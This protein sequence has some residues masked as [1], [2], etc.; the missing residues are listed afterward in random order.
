MLM[1]LQKLAR[2]GQALNRDPMQELGGITLYSFALNDPAGWGDLFGLY[3]VYPDDF[4][5]PLP[6]GGVHQSYDDLRRRLEGN[7]IEDDP[8]GESLLDGLSGLL[9]GLAPPSLGV[10]IG[11]HGRHHRFGSLGKLPH[12]QVATWRPGVK[13]ST[14]I[15]RVPVPPR[16]PGFPPK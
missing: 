8:L 11:L 2:L 12:V 10:R 6:P 1:R 4:V 16:T 13:G 15:I 5:G 9:R 7:G 3:T 14:C